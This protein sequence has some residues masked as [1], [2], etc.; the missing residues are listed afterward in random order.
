MSTEIKDLRPID[1]AE[2]ASLVE[3][4][5]ATLVECRKASEELAVSEEA[6]QD[7]SDAE[8]K[9]FAADCNAAIKAADKARIEFKKAWQEPYKRVET[10][11]NAELDAIKKV[12]AVYKCEHDRR[13][14][15]GKNMRYEALNEAYCEFLDANGLSTL[16]GNVPFDKLLDPRWLNKSYGEKKAVNELEDKVA[17]VMSDYRTLCGMQLHYEEAAQTRFFESLDLAAAI[18]WDTKEYNKRANLHDMKAEIDQNQ[19]EY[20]QPVQVFDMQDAPYPDVEVST[21]EPKSV[22]VISCEMTDSQKDYLLGVLK[23]AEIHGNL[24][25]SARF[26]DYRFCHAEVRKHV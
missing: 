25:R 24:C 26:A 16:E 4:M 14:A 7:L 22:Y 17:K 19:V 8:V 5:E 21:D 23:L 9:R 12:H 3:G 11:F 15:L 13:E 10:L 2:I 1:Q 18:D 20:E 6:V